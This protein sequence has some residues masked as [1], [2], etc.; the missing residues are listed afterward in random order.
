MLIMEDMGMKFYYKKNCY[1][2]RNDMLGVNLWAGYLSCK[3]RN[4]M[5]GGHSTIPYKKTYGIYVQD[6]RTCQG[7]RNATET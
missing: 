6:T 1:S 2:Y 3:E 4:E 5:P 7:L